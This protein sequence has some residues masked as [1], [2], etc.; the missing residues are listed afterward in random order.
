MKTIYKCFSRLVKHVLWKKTDKQAVVCMTGLI[1]HQSYGCR[2]KLFL[3]VL[4]I[5]SGQEQKAA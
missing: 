2:E 3:S 4:T 5:G 1:V